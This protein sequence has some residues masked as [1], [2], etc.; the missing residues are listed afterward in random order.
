[1][2]AVIPGSP[3]AERLIEQIESVAICN[4][5][6]P[7]PRADFAHYDE[8]IQ[9]DTCGEPLWNWYQVDGGPLRPDPYETVFV[10]CGEWANT[11]SVTYDGMMFA[12][13]NNLFRL[14]EEWK[15]DNE[16]VQ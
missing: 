13:R 2:K 4:G 9:C 3:L 8:R 1:M 5:H 12:M 10:A 15:D 14:E 6:T 16:P 11:S 7:R